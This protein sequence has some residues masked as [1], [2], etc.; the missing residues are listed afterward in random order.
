MRIKTC[1]KC[2]FIL[3]TRPKLIEKNGVCL[4]CINQIA[5]ENI[6][7]K[8]RQIW[9]SEYIKQNKT[10]SDYDCVVAVSGGKD[11][12]SIV[13]RLVENHNARPLLVNI[14]DEFTHTK[15]GK[16]N[17]DNLV[18]KYDLDLIT[19]RCNPRNFI[20]ETRKDFLNELNPLK[21]I[22]GRI[23]KI[24]IQIAQNYNIKLVFYG[25]NSAFEYGEK[26][27]LDIF[28][29]KSESVEAIFLGSIY[30]Y[31]IYGSLKLAREIGFRDL[32]YYNEW[33]RQG[34]IE[35]YTQIDSIGYIMHLWCKFIK[36][37]FQRVSDIA[38]RLVR[39]GVL[40]KDQ[41]M[42]MIKE[43][44]YICDPMAKIDFCKTIEITE[45]EFDMTVDK[46]VNRDLLIKDLNGQWR[47]KDLV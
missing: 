26:Q 10:N 47:R 22:E 15:A 5:K 14:T 8:A 7:Y 28:H 17:L 30:P 35:N 24:P 44:D 12:C 32:D 13:R 45:K 1:S 37:G 19:F 46:F 39:D 42:L 3:G 41:A 9:L 6:D 36:F 20:E 38:C 43:K 34:C 29:S 21:W 23:M 4:A 31:S 40:T 33:A 16:Y 18:K 11:S 2:G 25:E 27:E